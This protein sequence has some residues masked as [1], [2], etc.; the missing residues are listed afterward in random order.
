MD[1]K[2]RKGKER[3]GKERHKFVKEGRFVQMDALEAHSG[4]VSRIV[5]RSR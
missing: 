3:K 5:E 1:L 4:A 2:G